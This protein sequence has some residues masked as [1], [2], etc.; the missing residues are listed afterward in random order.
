MA[1]QRVVLEGSETG[2]LGDGLDVK[3][4]GEWASYWEK[5]VKAA[6]RWMR[7][8]HETGNTIYSRYTGNNDDVQRSDQDGRTRFNIFWSNIQVVLAAVFSRAPRAEVDR[9]H[10]DPNDDVARVAATILQRIFEAQFKLPDTSPLEAMRDSAQDRF[11]VGLGVLWI[12]YNFT[13]ET[14]DV[15]AVMDP[16]TGAELSPATQTEVVTDEQAPLDYVHWDDFLISPCR[17]WQE[18]RWVARAHF[19]GKSKLKTMFGQ[20]AADQIP[21]TGKSQKR[22]GTTASN[23]LRASPRDTALVWEIWD[24]DSR[25]VYWKPE[26]LDSVAMVQDDPLKLREFYPCNKPMRATYSTESFLP[27]SDYMMVRGQYLELEMI[28]ER[29][30][31]LTEA[32]RVVGIYDKSS[33]ELKAILNR[34]AFN[35]MIPVD[36]WAMFA[37]KGG[38]KGAVDWFP[39]EQVTMAIEKLTMRKQSVLQELYEVLGIADIMRG[40]SVASETATAQ[41]LK[42]KFGSARVTSTQNSLSEFLTGAMWLILEVVAKH[43]SPETII[44]V[45]QIMNTVDKQYAQPAVEALKSDPSMIYRLQ[46]STDSTSSP[47]WNEE[48]VQRTEFLQAVSQF[49]GMCMPLIEKNPGATPFLVQILQW[50]ATGFKSAK[51]IESVFDQALAALQK[52]LTTPKPPPPPSPEDIKDLASADKSIASSSRE[53][54]EGAARALEVGLPPQLALVPPPPSRMA[55]PPQGGPNGGGGPPAGAPQGPMP[56]PPGAP[57]QAGPVP[58]S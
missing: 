45:S 3:F 31:L 21:L 11:V 20:L 43:W 23:P 16:M 13:S 38:I 50:A 26:G 33:E 41:E 14:R 53:R 15:E 57:A 44:K 49:I 58:P 24:H 37:E 39:L 32:L 27:T 42:A 55:Q 35:Q 40:M 17:R 2:K 46:V 29:L 5:E 36:N 28:A 1:E 19:M 12:R 48:K 34:A 6:K 56:M 8:F 54:I 51:Q 9:A 7:E 4:A 47:N 25:R 52:D 10:L 30:T 22:G 18:K